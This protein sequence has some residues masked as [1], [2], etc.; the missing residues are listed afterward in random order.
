M[1][2]PSLKSRFGEQIRAFVG[3]KNSLGFPYDESIRIL[4]R[5][6]DFCVERFPEKDCLDR[7]FALAWLEKRDTEN[8]AGHRNRIMVI[9][10]F[11]KYLRAVGTEA[12]MIPISMTSKGPRYVPHIFNEAEIKA[13]F[14][15]ADSFRP[16]EKAPARH[17]VIPVFY[18]LLYCCGLRPAEAR[19]L[20]KENVDL[21]RG[22]V[23]VVESKGHKD[24]VV[25]VAD[26]LLQIMR[27]YSTLISEIYPDSD[28]FFPRYDGEGPYTKRWTEEMFWRCFSM[29]GITAFEGPKPRVYDFRHTFATECICRWMREGRDIDAMLPFLSAY[30]GHARYEDTLYYVHMV[31]DFYERVGTVDRTAWEKLLP[32]VHDEGKDAQFF[33]VVSSFLNVYLVKNRSC[34]SNTVKSYED[35]LNL[36]F[37]FLETAKAIPR[38]RANWSHF[39]RQNIQEFM[40]WLEKVR[41]CNRQTQLQRLAAIRS[42]VRYGGIIDLRVISIQADVEKIRYRKPAPAL[43]GYLTKEGLSAFLSQPNCQKRTGFRNMVFL[44]LMYDTAARCQE[45]LDLRIQDL[46]LHRTSP[47]VYLTGKGNK[48]RV[49]PILPKTAEHLRSYLKKF[50]PADNRK[51]DDYVFYAY[52]GPQR[53]MSPDTVTAFVKKYGESARQACTSIPARVHPHML[54]HTRAM[55]LYQDGIPL[56]MVSEFLGHAQIE[57]TK[58]YAHADT[59]MKRKAIQ[60]AANKLNDTIPDA[61]WNTDDEEMMLKLRG[62]QQY[63]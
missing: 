39:T 41:N 53:P 4:G 46:V 11:A 59:E 6:D 9:R 34:S 17:L 28:Y 29:A 54:R 63:K 26:D 2:R 36:F 56:A 49:V 13:F 20:K 50:H 44:V 1:T 18:R 45:M 52:G 30:M 55:H 8:T 42:F 32:E 38:Q 61:L 25:A 31:P 47:C 27:S 58:I 15:G 43:V 12:Y 51:R 7:E 23:Y 22:A 3:Y 21:V 14:H 24:R 40:D 48:T 62:K 33:A 10:E 19:L 5:F 16:H 60:Q 57:T 35:A 37:T